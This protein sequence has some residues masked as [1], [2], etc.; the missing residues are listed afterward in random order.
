MTTEKNFWLKRA[1]REV[2]KLRGY[3]SPVYP[4]PIESEVAEAERIVRHVC[5]VF[6]LHVSTGF[7]LTSKRITMW[8]TGS[9]GVKIMIQEGQV[10]IKLNDLKNDAL[11]IGTVGSSEVLHE[12]SK[13]IKSVIES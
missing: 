8:V 2:D 9:V 7:L 1:L 13:F 4:K 12:I 3:F 11:S 5:C 10:S 6:I